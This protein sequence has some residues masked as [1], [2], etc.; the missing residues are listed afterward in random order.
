MVR[1][2][3]LRTLFWLFR[4]AP[5]LPLFFLSSHLSPS[6]NCPPPPST[7]LTKRRA[8][9]CLGCVRGSVAAVAVPN[10]VLAKFVE[11][12]MIVCLFFLNGRLKESDFKLIKPSTGQEYKNTNKHEK[13]N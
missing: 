9:D 13:K 1:V 11:V 2:V 12:R 3:N 10:S 5:L 8:A 7:T 6:A 4:F